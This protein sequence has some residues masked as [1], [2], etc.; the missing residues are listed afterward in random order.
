[1]S[2]ELGI[3]ALYGL[4]IVGIIL[5]QD[6]AAILTQKLSYLVS[7]RDK[8]V[9]PSVLSNRLNRAI[10]NSVVAMAY[11]APAVIVIHLQGLSTSTTLLAAQVFLLAR[12]FYAVLYA[13]GIPWLRSISWLVGLF[14]ALFLYYSV[15]Q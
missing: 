10:D 5:A 13:L 2:S 15:F 1:M 12:L 9:T 14:A 3:L 7:A 4:L 6:L 8:P 11:F